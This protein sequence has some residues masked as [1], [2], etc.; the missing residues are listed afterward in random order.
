MNGVKVGMVRA[1][2]K[3]RRRRRWLHHSGRFV[4]RGLLADVDGGGVVVARFGGGVGCDYVSL[5]LGEKMDTIDVC[6]RSK[7]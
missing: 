7:I 1:V 5:Q 2:V 3:R 6:F 4:R